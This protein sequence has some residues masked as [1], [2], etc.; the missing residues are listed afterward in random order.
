MG[1]LSIASI[2]DKTAREGRKTS[3][4]TYDLLHSFQQKKNG[5]EERSLKNSLIV[6]L[7]KQTTHLSPIF[8]AADFFPVDYSTIFVLMNLLASYVVVLIQFE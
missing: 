6:Q 2:C 8:S 7:L 5:R 3:A 4:L 1:A